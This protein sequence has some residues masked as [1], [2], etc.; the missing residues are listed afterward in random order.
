MVLKAL[1]LRF[2]VFSVSVYGTVMG[3]RVVEKQLNHRHLIHQNLHRGNMEFV[4]HEGCQGKP[5]AVRDIYLPGKL[6]AVR[7]IYRPGRPGVGLQWGKVRL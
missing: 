6:E 5:G 7:D 4:L 2:P 3:I 1:W